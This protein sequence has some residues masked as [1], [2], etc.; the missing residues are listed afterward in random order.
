[1]AN[2]KKLLLDSI[3][4]KLALATDA[5]IIRLIETAGRHMVQALNRGNQI[6]IAGNGGSAADA[7]HFAAELSGKFLNAQRRP[8][9]ATALTVN[10]SNLT[11][12]GNDFGYEQVFSRQLEG[13]GHPG[14]MFVGITTS[15]NSANI[16][17]A[18]SIARQ[19]DI[20]SVGLLGNGGGK[21]KDRCDFAIIVPS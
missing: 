18:F 19:K 2:V 14:D 13:L 20:L 3:Q 12:I 16:L 15:G 6:L 10:T 17:E 9:P 1:M 4:V 11:A 21:A 5:G 7:Q 8:L